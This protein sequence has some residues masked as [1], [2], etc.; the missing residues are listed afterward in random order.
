MQVDPDGDYSHRTADLTPPGAAPPYADFQS[1]K[2]YSW[3]IVLEKNW[4]RRA[5]LA[6]ES[7]FICTPEESNPWVKIVNALVEIT[8][9]LTYHL[10]VRAVSFYS[11]SVGPGTISYQV[12]SAS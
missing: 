7:N 1:L 10:S 11:H 5:K 2:F 12:R 9:L 3:G 8:Y 4:G 6:L